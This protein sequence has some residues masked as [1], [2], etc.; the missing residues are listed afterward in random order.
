MYYN[1]DGQPV[2]REKKPQL[3]T[4]TYAWPTRSSSIKGSQPYA[5]SYQHLIQNNQKRKH[6]PSSLA[7]V[8]TNEEPYIEDGYDHYSEQR[9]EVLRNHGFWPHLRREDGEPLRSSRHD[10]GNARRPTQDYD[11]R[12]PELRR[13]DAFV[14]PA[15]QIAK[16][17]NS[18]DLRR[19]VLFEPV[20]AAQPVVQSISDFLSVTPSIVG[21]V[22]RPLFSR[23]QPPSRWSYSSSDSDSVLESNDSLTFEDSSIFSLWRGGE[24]PL[25]PLSPWPH[26]YGL[27]RPAFKDDKL[28]EYRLA[29]PSLLRNVNQPMPETPYLH[30]SWAT[31][32]PVEFLIALGHHALTQG[33]DLPLLYGARPNP[34]KQWAEEDGVAEGLGKFNN[35]VEE[36]CKVEMQ[37]IERMNERDG[38][39]RKVFGL[40]DVCERKHKELEQDLSIRMPSEDIIS[41]TLERMKIQRGANAEVEMEFKVQ[42]VTQ[43]GFSAWRMKTGTS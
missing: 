28:E 37:T 23:D 39:L 12:P 20:P 8:E 3:T 1:A 17:E 16:P 22:P 19:S 43:E 14:V 6:P 25:T 15:S 18:F 24:E 2:H 11:R 30:L 40:D 10:D 26:T 42:E 34:D 32:T 5:N 38:K 27:N 33:L 29:D 4:T 7:S 36:M 13:E 41:N 9:H 35:R 31:M 21:L